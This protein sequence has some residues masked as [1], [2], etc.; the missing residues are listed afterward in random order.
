MNKAIIWNKD[1][2]ENPAI[3][4]YW[5]GCGSPETVVENRN[6]FALEYNLAPNQP[7]DYPQKLWLDKNFRDFD[8]DH[9]EAYKTRDGKWVIINS[10]Y[11]YSGNLAENEKRDI[12]FACLGLKKIYP[13]YAPGT[14]GSTTYVRVIEDARSHRWDYKQAILAYEALKILHGEFKL[15]VRDNLHKHTP[16]P[17]DV[18]ND[19]EKYFDSL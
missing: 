10:P 14:S 6:R 2:T 9:F 19:L 7:R 11:D 16:L 3:W 18:I 15:A 8:F 17:T 4:Q 1:R 13:L 5:G 12:K